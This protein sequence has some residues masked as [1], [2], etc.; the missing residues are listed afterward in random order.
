MKQLDLA[1][2]GNCNVASLVDVHGRHVW[3]CFP[4]LDGEPLFS[5]LVDGPEP[6]Q[7]FMDLVL[8]KQ[9]RAEQRYLHN[10]AGLETVL[11]DAAGAGVRI[12][13]LAP[14]FKRFGRIFRPP[15]LIRRIEPVGGHPRVRIRIRPRFGYG[16]DKPHRRTGSNHLRYVAS[17]MAV[18]VTTDLAV[19]YLAEEVEFMLD[20]PGHL[21][22]GPDET[23]SE[24]PHTVA[25]D[26]VEETIAYWQDWTRYLSVPFEWQSAVIRA[27]ITLKLCSFEETGGI[28]AALTTSIPEAANSGRNWDYRFCWLRDAFFTVLALNKLGATKT[29]EEYVRYL[30]N[31]VLYEE[32]RS[33]APVY[34]IVPG[35]P[36]GEWT[37]TGLRGFRG[38]G[39]VRIGNAAADQVQ[40]DIY[41]SVVLAANQ[42]FYDQ[43]LPY[44]A[45]IELYRQLERVGRKAIE[46]AFEP[47]AGL[48]EYRGRT[49]IHT[50]SAAMCWAAVNGLRRVAKRLGLE[51]ERQHWTEAG[52]RMRATILERAWR[53][54]RNSFVA[55][56]DGGG[57]DA[58]L[59]L[60][61][62]IGIIAAKDE[63][64]LGTLAAIERGLIHD[65]LVYRYDTAD[66]FG[67]PET[68]FL[69]CTFWYIDALAA[70]GKQEK[71]RGL[72]ERVLALR[73]HVGLLSE[74]VDPRTGE[75]WGNFPQTYSLVGMIVSAMRLSR[76]WEDGLWHV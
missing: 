11:T 32:D 53:P 60:L 75:L 66:D 26:F 45:G 55:C 19:S 48:W 49:R 33:P 20:R 54:E 14:R 74:D 58:S 3:F 50:F 13:D 23:M 72:F 43:R 5:A 9:V 70:A 36:M 71:A 69:V 63:R 27:A 44:P 67:L 34:P 15:M 4:R 40:T 18:R 76:S 37:A 17:E 28:V 39:P 22:I 65:G 6:D 57:L 29:M 41:G 1:V 42:M 12:T 24:A 47:D 31:A 8:A 2:I 51:T 10:T 25:R 7:G 21:L 68:A 62:E 73:N 30:M 56:L 16:A 35:T 38:M 64:F 52:E 61:P 59:L 46:S